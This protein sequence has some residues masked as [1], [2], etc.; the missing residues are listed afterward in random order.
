MYSLIKHGAESM[1]PSMPPDQRMIEPMILLPLQTSLRPLQTCLQA[2]LEVPLEQHLQEANIPT[3][4]EC[5]QMSSTMRVPV[6]CFLI[7]HTNRECHIAPSSRSRASHT[8]V[9]LVRSRFRGRR[10]IHR[11]KYPW[12]HGGRLCW[13]PPWG[14]QR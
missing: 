5:L 6:A 7:A 10:G 9:V 4:R 14:N 13:Q 3:Q 12:P 1:M 8:M 2:L 11:W